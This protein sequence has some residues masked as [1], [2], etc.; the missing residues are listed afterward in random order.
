MVSAR[1]FCSFLVSF[2]VVGKLSV[3]ARVTGNVYRTWIC[4]NRGAGCPAEIQFKVR[5]GT[6]KYEVLKVQTTHAPE[7]LTVKRDRAHL[8]AQGGAGEGTSDPP[9]QP[10]PQ[11]KRRAIK[12]TAAYVS[13][14]PASQT[15]QS[16]GHI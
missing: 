2:C 16:R 13:T 9:T 10:P 14:I 11:K 15:K 7:C 4:P 12:Y 3:G 6:G 1:L 5:P 8:E